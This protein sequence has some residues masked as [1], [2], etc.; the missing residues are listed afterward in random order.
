MSRSYKEAARV[1]ARAGLCLKIFVNAIGLLP[2]LGILM[3]D[4]S[5][6]NRT[7]L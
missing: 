4:W 2:R 5:G 1:N 7:L 3:S 6:R